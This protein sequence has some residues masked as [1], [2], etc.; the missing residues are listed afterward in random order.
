MVDVVQL[1]LSQV[2]LHVEAANN[3]VEKKLLAAKSDA[4]MRELVFI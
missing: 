4:A 1:G 2:A 3:D